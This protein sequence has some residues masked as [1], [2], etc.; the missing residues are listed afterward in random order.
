MR[1]VRA[2]MSTGCQP[3]LIGTG[4][5]TASGYDLNWEMSVGKDMKKSATSARRAATVLLCGV[6]VLSVSICALSTS[7]PVHWCDNHAS[8]ELSYGSDLAPFHRLAETDGCCAHMEHPDGCGHCHPC[9]SVPLTMVLLVPVVPGS[10]TGS[11]STLVVSEAKVGAFSEGYFDELS[12]WARTDPAPYI[13][14]TL[15]ALASVRLLI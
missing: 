10:D 13:C 2:A 7:L 6:A 8:F 14:G 12:V 9:E 11:F 4:G 1:Q 15:E 5:N 3:G